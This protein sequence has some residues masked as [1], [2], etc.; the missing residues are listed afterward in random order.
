MG[1]FSWIILGLVAGAIARVLHPGKDPGGCLLTI[2][3]GV[4]GAAVGGYIGTWLGWGKVTGFDLR[5]MGLAVMGSLVLLIS[6][7]LLFGK[8]D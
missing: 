7:R 2:L 5:S 3:L 8:R 4:G 1:V 6:F